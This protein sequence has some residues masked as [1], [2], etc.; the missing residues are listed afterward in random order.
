MFAIPI[1]LPGCAKRFPKLRIGGEPPHRKAQRVILV[2][3]VDRD[4]HWI[5]RH[6]AIRDPRSAIRSLA[7]ARHRRAES[8]VG[9]PH[10]IAD[11]APG[12]R[13]PHPDPGSRIPDP[14][15]VHCPR[16]RIQRRHIH[17]VREVDRDRRPGG[18]QRA[19]PGSRHLREPSASGDSVTRRRRQC[20][21]SIQTRWRDIR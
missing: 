13:I 4:C 14:D 5:G 1:Q 6:A 20:S 19:E 7:G 12:S 21:R 18:G 16:P 17:Q 10:A 8:G 15:C 2:E 9:I 11:P 3:D